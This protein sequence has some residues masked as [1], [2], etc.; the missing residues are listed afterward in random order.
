[1]RRFA[2]KKSS[3]DFFRICSFFFSSGAGV[4]TWS[5]SPEAVFQRRQPTPM[6]TRALPCLQASL[7]VSV[8]FLSG[9]AQAHIPFPNFKHAENSNAVLKDLIYENT[10]Y[11]PLSSPNGK[12]SSVLTD[13]VSSVFMSESERMR[14]V[15]Q[16]L[17]QIPGLELSWNRRAQ[18]PPGVGSGG[19]SG[20]SGSGWFS[21]SGFLA[22][23]G[24]GEGG[25]SGS[26]QGGSSG[27]GA[28]TDDE[29]MRKVWQKGSL[30]PG[31]RRQQG[32][33]FAEVDINPSDGCISKNE[34][35]FPEGQGHVFEYLAG[36]SQAD[37]VCAAD[38]ISSADLQAFF[39]PDSSIFPSLSTCEGAA[40]QLN[41]IQRCW[42]TCMHAGRVSAFVKQRV[43]VLAPVFVS[44]VS[45]FQF[46]SS[47]SVIRYSCHPTQC[48]HC[49]DDE[50]GARHMLCVES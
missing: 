45:F 6:P 4:L 9:L 3:R 19:F 16:E 50:C 11:L 31:N 26:G 46:L 38:Q 8:L 35:P 28:G 40:L 30:K 24:S 37:G 42:R 43:Y 27:S 41:S 33:A 44:A 48:L 14:K 32:P 39:P 21:G 25:S 2:L 47:L 29:R 13:M 23:S 7:V 20:S 5:A 12:V 22:S 18:D 1:V 10:K 15:S 17:F 36:L 34:F 49:G